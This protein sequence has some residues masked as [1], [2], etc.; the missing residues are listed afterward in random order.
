MTYANCG[1]CLFWG[2]CVPK[3]VKFCEHYTPLREEILLE[4]A[5][6]EERSAYRKEWEA[7]LR[8]WTDET[9]E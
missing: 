3:K 8:E 9:T 4:Q 1:E 5:I 7:Y 2:C 6:E